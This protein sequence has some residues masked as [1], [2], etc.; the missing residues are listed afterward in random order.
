MVI[1]VLELIWPPAY[2]ITY[3]AIGI[4]SNEYIAG[5]FDFRPTRGESRRLDIDGIGRACFCENM[6]RLERHYPLINGKYSFHC[7]IQ[8]IHSFPDMLDFI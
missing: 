6:R 3:Y 1:R 8:K 2:V 5:E 7:A 4:M